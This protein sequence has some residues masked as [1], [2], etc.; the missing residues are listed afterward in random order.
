MD[1]VVRGRNVDVPEHYRQHVADKLGRI[2]RYD[3]KLIGVDVELTHE[4]NRRQSDACQRVEITCT[5]RGPVV[6]SEACAADFYSALDVA[7]GKLE[8][9]LRRVADRRRVHHGRHTPRSV[10]AAT[11][12]AAAALFEPPADD[13][14][15]AGQEQDGLAVD[16]RSGGA[17]TDLLD[18]S[19]TDPTAVGGDGDVDDHPPGRVV[20]DKVHP[21]EPMSID[22]ALL[23]MELVGHDFFLFQCQDTGRPSVVYRRHGYDYGVIRL[24]E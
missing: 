10:H 8:S 6:R 11:G 24:A 16:T 9:R 21:S 22:Q 4:N 18:G 12:E 13:R 15:S 7:V 23:R 3:H 14:G 1:I 19:G 17:A 20:R 2:E 5:S